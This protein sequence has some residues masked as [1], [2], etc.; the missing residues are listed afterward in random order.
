MKAAEIVSP[1]KIAMRELSVPEPGAEEVVVKLKGSGLCVSNLPVWQGRD[2]FQYPQEPGSPGHEGFGVVEQ[3]GQNTKGLSKGDRVALISYHAYAEYDKAHVDSVV[4]IPEVLKDDMFPGEPLACAVNV[5]RRSDIRPGQPVVVIGAGFLGCLLI[6]L[7]KG[8]AGKIIAVS[9]RKT[10]LEFAE[11]AGADQLIQFQNP[12]DTA[13]E[14]I[15]IAGGTVPRVI[16]ATGEQSSIDLATE[17]VS[18]GGKLIIAGYHQGGLRSIN[19]Q[20]WNWKGIDVINAHERDPRVYTQGLREAVEKTRTGI[21]RP[22]ELITHCFELAD[23]NEAFRTLHRR[24]EGF[25]KAVIMNGSH[26]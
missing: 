18:E 20:S 5:F 13:G 23:L 24:P 10:S 11:K 4:K 16:E 14:V 17:L 3:L 19:L 7:I 9:Q 12:A 1:G 15:R 6:Q 8:T 21:L 2:W 26:I 22:G 25:L